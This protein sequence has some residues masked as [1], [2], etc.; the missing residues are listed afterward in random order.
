L[1]GSFVISPDIANISFSM[2]NHAIGSPEDIPSKENIA[3]RAWECA[4]QL[5]LDRTQLA[6]QK[7]STNFCMYDGK[8]GCNQI[9]GKATFDKCFEEMTSG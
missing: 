9:V 6:E 8:G 7:V 4:I 2:R 5:G 1:A 3:K